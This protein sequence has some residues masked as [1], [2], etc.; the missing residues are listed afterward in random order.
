MQ[1]QTLK[2][3]IE[4]FSLYRL[5]IASV[6]FFMT[7]AFV[8][9]LRLAADRL[10]AKFTR[11]RLQIS[12]VYPVLRLLIWVGA[13]A[14]VVFAIFSPP[15]NTII[16]ISASAGLAIGL[17]A[18]DLIKNIIAGVLIL[19]DRPFR[20]GDMIQTGDHYGEVTIIGLR[21][22]RIHT[23]GDSL[24]SLPNS[25]L[26]GQAVSN[27]NS[28]ELDELIEVEFNLPAH[29]DVQKLKKLAW[30]SAACSPYVFLKKPVR[31]MVEDRF[32]RTFL[33]RLKIKAYVLDIRYERMLASDISE[34]FK[35][36]LVEHRLITEAT[37]LGLLA[38]QGE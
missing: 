13:M 5:L 28:G 8:S 2:T 16:A 27:S 25:L 33:T 29:L 20:V 19:F 10:A 26:L 30:E 31:V 34:R 4:Q 21:S 14:F 24:I 23:F 37:A 11:Y 18:Q 6:F 1:D 17:G 35:Q 12:S 3:I 22:T 36:T 32:D 7:W 15:I 9:L 38:S